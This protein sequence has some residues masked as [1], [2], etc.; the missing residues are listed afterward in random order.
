MRITSGLVIAAAAVMTGAFTTTLPASASQPPP[1]STLGSVD[2]NGYC[3]S[4]GAT[5]ARLTA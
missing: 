5:G 3:R 4:L 2:F 1:G